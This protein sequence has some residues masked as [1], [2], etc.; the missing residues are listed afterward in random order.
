MLWLWSTF[1]GPLIEASTQS[2]SIKATVHWGHLHRLRYK[3]TSTASSQ[4]HCWKM[5]GTHRLQKRHWKGSGQ[6][7]LFLQPPFLLL[8]LLVLLPVNPT[9][10]TPSHCLEPHPG[11]RCPGAFVVGHRFYFDPETSECLKFFHWGCDGEN[12]FQTKQNCLET[13]MSGQCL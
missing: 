10:A 6:T 1:D 4:T 5:Y 9:L 8:L 2:N 11:N 13:C 12:N 7:L 3:A